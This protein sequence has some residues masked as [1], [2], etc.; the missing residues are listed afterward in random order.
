MAAIR[1][2]ASAGIDTAVLEDPERGTVCSSTLQ[3]IAAWV[4]DQP[5]RAA[6]AVRTETVG[7]ELIRDTRWSEEPVAVVMSDGHVL[8][9]V[10]T[11]HC[12]S[13]SSAGL[14]LLSTGTNPRFGP[15]RLHTSLAR[16]L[17]SEGFSVLRIER[18]GGGTSAGEEARTTA[19]GADAEVAHPAAAP[20]VPSR[21]S[22]PRAARP[23]ARFIMGIPSAFIF[24][25]LSFGGK[26]DGLTRTQPYTP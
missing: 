13:P 10:R 3:T 16:S 22:T 14:V 11:S 17:A 26:R 5:T 6:R 21:I 12:G 24:A 19:S 2:D 20:S 9:G 15:A 25:L 18:R 4:N 8:H 7:A 23:S 1:I